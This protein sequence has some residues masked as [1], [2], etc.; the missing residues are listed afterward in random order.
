MLLMKNEFE[1]VLKNLDDVI[2]NRLKAVFDKLEP[3]RDANGH[4]RYG[5]WVSSILE[6]LFDYRDHIVTEFAEESVDHAVYEHQICRD[7]KIADEIRGE[8]I[9]TSR[10]KPLRE[11]Y[12]GDYYVNAETWC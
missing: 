9:E 8:I 11:V 7:D 6:D 2:D 3:L 10:R 1:E 12:N 4:A 5:G